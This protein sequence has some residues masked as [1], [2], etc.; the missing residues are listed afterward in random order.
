MQR[1]FYFFVLFLI[2][3]QH[4][5]AQLPIYS[6]DFLQIGASAEAAALGNS[7]TATTKNCFATFYNP[8]GLT[9]TSTKWQAALLHSE[10]FAGMAQYDFAAAS[11][12]LNDSATIALSL[13]RFGVDNIQNTLE[14]F[15]NQG[16]IDFS[17][18]KKFSTAD[19][20]IFFSYSRKSKIEG[21]TYGGNAKIIYR[22]QGEF[23]SCYGI[24]ADIG[25]QYQLKKWN[26]GLLARD[27]T[28]TFNAWIFENDEKLKQ[29]FDS[30]QNILP[31]NSVEVTLPRLIFGISRT[32]SITSDISLAP[33][34]DFDLTFD[35]KRNVL[36]NSSYIS[37]DPHLGIETAYKNLVFLRLGVNNIQKIND[38]DYNSIIFQ[39]NV[40]IGIKFWGINIDYALTDIGNQIFQYSHLISIHYSWKN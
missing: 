3:S 8:A 28:S 10:Y 16:N 33:N 30:T 26:F 5:E 39:P 9:K 31:K 27:I 32:F 34:L 13:I 24:G 11:Y 12:K 15:D 29:V 4:I 2:F 18:I 21:L 6:N 7:V 23:A 14:L 1:F 19:Y 17:R 38:L 25:L 40:G 36:V 37:L 20:A 22:K 35:G